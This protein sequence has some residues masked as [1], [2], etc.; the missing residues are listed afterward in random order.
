MSGHLLALALV[1]PLNG[2]LVDRIG[3][4]T[5]HLRCVAAFTPSSTSCGLAWS[6]RS[7]IGS[8][9]L[10]GMSGGLLAGAILRHASSHWLFLVNLPVGLVAFAL[11]AVMLRGEARPRGLDLAG[12][13]LLS[14]GS[15]L[16][17]FGADHACGTIGQSTLAISL[18]LL[19]LFYR[20]ARR[21]GEAAL[22]GLRL[23]RN[24][25]SAASV[26]VMSIMNGVWFAGQMLVAPTLSDAC[27]LSPQRTGLLLAPLGPGMTCT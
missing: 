12:L 1:L 7:L 22:I 26:V 23:L 4:R 27:G 24:R 2:W 20:H 5:V 10:R 19:A 21:R 18:V 14:P 16:F 6:A 15:V 17:L 11:A 3:A 25:R 8:R 13:A 9:V